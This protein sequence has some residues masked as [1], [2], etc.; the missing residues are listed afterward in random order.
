M[1]KKLLK[2]KLIHI[3]RKRRG[4][5]NSCVPGGNEKGWYHYIKPTSLCCVLI[6]HILLWFFKVTLLRNQVNQVYQNTEEKGL[7]TK[8]KVEGKRDDWVKVCDWTVSVPL[9]KLLWS[10]YVHIFYMHISFLHISISWTVLDV[11]FSRLHLLFYF[12]SYS[13]V[14]G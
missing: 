14:V 1:A 11:L 4:N 12:I 3:T 9:R 10:D 6:M 13:P 5:W 7:K 2:H 8:H